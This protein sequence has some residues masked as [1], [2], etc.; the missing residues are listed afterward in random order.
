M[1]IAVAVIGY[2]APV[3]SLRNGIY[4]VIVMDGI[5]DTQQKFNADKIEI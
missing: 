1:L 5:T 3:A 4:N 2:V